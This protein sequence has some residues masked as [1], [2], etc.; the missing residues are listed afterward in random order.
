MI[1]KMLSS[2]I[3]LIACGILIH[4]TTGKLSIC[5]AF[6]YH[7][8]HPLTLKMAS[9]FLLFILLLLG[10]V[11]VFGVSNKLL[12]YYRL[13]KAIS[14]IPGLPTHWLWGN[15]HQVLSVLEHEK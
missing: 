14:K 5:I 1:F 4:E 13:C 2:V 15:L 11:V 3:H 10:A 8:P 6:A 7:E 9:F 12:N